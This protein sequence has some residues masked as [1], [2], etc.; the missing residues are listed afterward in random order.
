MCGLVVTF[1]CLE[2]WVWVQVLVLHYFLYGV[3][4]REGEVMVLP[5]VHVRFLID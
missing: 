4:E 2:Q 3:V 1:K 5:G